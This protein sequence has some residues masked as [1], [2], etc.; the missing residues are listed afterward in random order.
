M[1][2][3]YHVISFLELSLRTVGIIKT[4]NGSSYQKQACL[5]TGDQSASEQFI[6][7]VHLHSYTA[8]YH[9]F[10]NLRILFIRVTV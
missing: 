10:L 5:N 4:L 1:C 3:L 6:S 8:M 2:G 9:R 7:Q